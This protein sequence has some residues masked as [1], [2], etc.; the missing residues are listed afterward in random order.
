MIKCPHCQTTFQADENDYAAIVA[1]VRTDEFDRELRSRL[2]D[3]TERLRAE[4]KARELELEREKERVETQHERSASALKQRISEL[5]GLLKSFEAEKRAALADENARRSEEQSKIMAEKDRQLAALESK[6]ALMAKE[7]EVELTKVRADISDDF[8]KKEREISEL[9]SKMNEQELANQQRMA[10]LAETHR[11]L[12]R[13]KDEEIEH[14]KDL[15]SRLS[16]KLLGETLEQ[17]CQNMFN[18]ARSQGQYLEAYFEKDNDTTPGGTKGD[19]IFRDYL[20][21]EEYISIMFEM[22]NEDERSVTKHKNEEFFH[23]LDKDRREKGCEYAVLVSALEADNELYNEGIV[24]VS[25]RYD[26]MFVVRPQMFMSVIS[27]LSRSARRG[28][29]QMIS[30]KG[31]LEK[32]RMQSID[33]TNFE[34]KRDKLVAD[35]RKLVD[36]HETKHN[37][38]MEAIDKAIAAAEKQAENLRKVKSIFEMS[39]QK[40][41]KA[42]DLIETNLTIK[43]LTYKN[44]TMRALFDEAKS[45]R[46]D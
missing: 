14:Y 12:L 37:D 4:E 1:Q 42:E 38:A 35:F 30:L 45:S 2:T 25:Y 24:D 23:K 13:A 15:K 33:V 34:A 26:K 8:H 36:A 29:Q 32:A 41:L 7:H 3:A 6:I 19:F 39:R 11:T 21:G 44:P 31:E 5:E 43:K 18:R 22:K 9:R 20:N 40:L 28:A 27:L 10:Q 17:H 16:T 46:E